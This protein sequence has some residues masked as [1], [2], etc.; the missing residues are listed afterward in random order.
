MKSDTGFEH[1]WQVRREAYYNHW[2]RTMPKNQIQFA[3]RQHWLLFQEIMRHPSFNRGKRCLEV[4]CG[5]GTIS[6]YFADHGFDCTLVDLSATVIDIAQEIFRRNRLPGRFRV[7]DANALDFPDASF[8]VVVSIGLLEHFRNVATPL[9]EQV[10]V[11]D[12]GG[13][14]LAYIVPEYRQNVQRRYDWINE[15]LKG[16]VEPAGR[17]QKEKIYRSRYSSEKYMPILKKLGMKHLR[18][19][20]VY[21]VPMIS[22]SVDFPFSLMPERSEAAYV[23]TLETM[24]AERKR[25]SSRNP[26]LCKEGY[27]QALLIWGFR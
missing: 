27:G 5:R 2:T 6:A 16:Y 23:R 10:R 13:L 8:D 19:S 9:R 4:G 25:H 14:L 21:P 3:F 17:Q 24:L 7:G 18:A 15:I 11:L 1:N 12:S 22:H 26:W 20:G